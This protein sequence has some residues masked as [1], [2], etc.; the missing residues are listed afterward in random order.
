MS[1]SVHVFF[2]FVTVGY[3]QVKLSIASMKEISLIFLMM[4]R[5]KRITSLAKDQQQ[6]F[7]LVLHDHAHRLKI[8]KFD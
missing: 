1:A 2:Y 7:E 4:T 8:D 5:S 3:I 6:E